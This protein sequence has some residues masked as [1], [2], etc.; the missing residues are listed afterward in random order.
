M[1]VAAANAYAKAHGKNTF[2]VY[3]GRWN[4]M[5]QVSLTSW[6]WPQLT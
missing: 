1:V 3:Q 2:V 5:A 4:V 6:L